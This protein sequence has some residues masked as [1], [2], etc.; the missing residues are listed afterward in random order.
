M[1][2]NFSRTA[3]RNIDS[4]IIVKAKLVIKLVQLPSR[5]AETVV[6]RLHIAEGVVDINIRAIRITIIHIRH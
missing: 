6:V 4:A 5:P 1:V 3:S 2:I